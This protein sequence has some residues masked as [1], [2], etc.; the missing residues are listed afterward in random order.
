MNGAATILIVDDEFQNR[1]LLEAL[2]HPEGYLHACRRQRRRGAGLD[3][4][5]V[6]RT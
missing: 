4:A 1:K 6:R 2:L 5:S 3:C